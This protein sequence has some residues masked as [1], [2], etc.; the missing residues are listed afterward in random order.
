[1]KRLRLK[2]RKEEKGNEAS[3]FFSV[4]VVMMPLMATK[5]VIVIKK[6]KYG[7][8]YD[9]FMGGCSGSS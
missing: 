1:M 4:D 3:P 7:G 9:K 6:G 2:E 5:A 8:W